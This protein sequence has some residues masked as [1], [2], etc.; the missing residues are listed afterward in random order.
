MKDTGDIRHLCIIIF[1]LG[2]ILGATFIYTIDYYSGQ[3]DMEVQVQMVEDIIQN[4]EY[5]LA[6]V[7]NLDWKL[8]LLIDKYNYYQ[9]VSRQILER[10]IRIICG[11][12]VDDI[13]YVNLTETFTQELCTNN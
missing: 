13:E 5:F 4:P 6:P 10:Q 12:P 1:V 3:R 7:I 8:G 2:C 11:N 9:P